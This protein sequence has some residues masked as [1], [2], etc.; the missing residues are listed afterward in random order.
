MTALR[1]KPGD[2]A[3][4]IGPPGDLAIGAYVDVLQ[5]AP[6]HPEEHLPAWMCKVHSRMTCTTIVTIRLPF[7]AG[8]EIRRMRTGYTEPGDVVCI[9]DCY[10]QPLRP[11]AKTKDVPAPP[12]ELELLT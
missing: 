10:L 2:I 4:I 11:P 8:G 9:C 3:M 5:R 7:F 6:D 12:V 1:C